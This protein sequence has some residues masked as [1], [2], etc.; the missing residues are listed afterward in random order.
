MSRR[1]AVVTPR[2]PHVLAVVAGLLVLPLALIFA[3]FAAEVLGAGGTDARFTI[4][5][6]FLFVAYACAGA[7]F[8]LVWPGKSWRWG[9]W[10]S[11]LP[12]V[13]V[14][15]VSP[16]AT[17]ALLFSVVLPACAGALA[18]ARLHS[19]RPGASLSGPKQQQT[20]MPP[21]S[22]AARAGFLRK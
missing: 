17:V 22:R 1:G 15:F 9:A 4:R 12:F 8:G 2:Y 18:A 7:F 13:W 21:E 10:M 5:A 16:F 11:A 19:K 6:A 20:F 14:S 3:Q